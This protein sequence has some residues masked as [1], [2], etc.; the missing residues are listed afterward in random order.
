VGGRLLG[1]RGVHPTG[2]ISV[3]RRRR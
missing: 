3:H 2:R 1:R